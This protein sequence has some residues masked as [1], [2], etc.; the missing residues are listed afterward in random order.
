[1][2]IKVHEKF[3]TYIHRHGGTGGPANQ[4]RKRGQIPPVKTFYKSNE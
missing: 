1:M 4:V 2:V 3:L